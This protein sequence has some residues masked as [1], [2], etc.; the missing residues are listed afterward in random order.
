VATA[1]II[2]TGYPA[3]LASGLTTKKCSFVTKRVSE[4]VMRRSDQ[5]LVRSLHAAA[6]HP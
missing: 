2:I 4:D 3:V 1:S 5:N 6:S